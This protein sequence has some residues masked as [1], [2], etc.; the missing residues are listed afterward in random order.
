[1]LDRGVWR[2]S[3]HPN[4]FFEWILWCGFAVL[5]LGGPWGWIGLAAPALMLYTIVFVTGI[6]PTEA[7][8]L[9]SRG[10]DYR[11]YKARTPML[12]PIPRR[13]VSAAAP[14]QSA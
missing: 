3:R 1:M 11:A 9:A 14:L 7:Q 10:E 8:A 5:G 2:Y 13:R 6:P 12:L 4:Y